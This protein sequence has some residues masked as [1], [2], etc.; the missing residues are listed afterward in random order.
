MK[1]RPLRVVHILTDSNVGGAGR[2]LLYL[3]SGSGRGRFE[4]T[5]M[6]PEGSALVPR[7]AAQGI[8]A[9]QIPG[10]N[11]SRCPAAMRT[12][13]REIKRI[14]P[15][16]VHTHSSYTGRMAALKAGVPVRIM[17]KHSSD[18][19]P[20][21]MSS[22]PV[23]LFC[24]AHWKRTLSAAIA[25]D[26]ASARSLIACGMPE[27]YIN[28]IYN[29]AP[30]PR[31]VS[32][33]EKK[34]LRVSLGIPDD[35]VVCGT[36]SR[37][38][39]EKGIVTLLRA[40]SLV[41]RQ[42]PNVRFIIC[43]SGS[44]ETELKELCSRYGLDGKVLFCGFAGDP[45]PYMSLCRLLISPSD[46]VETSSL[47]VIEGMSMG[48]VPVVTDVGGSS[49]LAEGC[50]LCVPP[51]DPPALAEAVVSLLRDSARTDILSE[52]ASRRY[53]EHFT[54]ERMREMTEILYARTLGL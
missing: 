1:E 50:G 39:A 31:A 27:K 20:R 32:D 5:V 54:A 17:T 46:S 49:T 18:M 14:S 34:A 28:I 33:A 35:C 19:P 13:T 38:E 43:G 4:Y 41:L 6:L 8:A 26:D 25:T 7:F 47:S 29:G 37:L 36:F 42:L 44:R 22:F 52:E 24:S 10:M 11:A 45:A 48:L 2:Q 40:A 12:L 23:R 53:A 30:A 16:I 9:V 15:D 51:V 3:T 21:L